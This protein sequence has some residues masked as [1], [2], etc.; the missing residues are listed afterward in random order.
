M[1]VLDPYVLGVGILIGIGSYFWSSL[2][3]PLR[4]VPGPTVSLFT[5]W[6]LKW[7]EFH[8]NRTRYVHQLHESYGPVVRIGPN[9]VSFV[10]TEAVKEIYSSGG[11][12]YDKTEF[13]NLFQVY[14]RR[15]AEPQRPGR[16]E[17]CSNLQPIGP[18]SAH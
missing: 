3:S 7:H 9:E 1:T 16:Q 11:S 8:A 13:Y 4:K 17:V 2:S 12:G 18:C 15:Y 14:A 5:S 6:I 10:S